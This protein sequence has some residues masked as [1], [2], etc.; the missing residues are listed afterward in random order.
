MPPCG[1]SRRTP[2]SITPGLA[3]CGRHLPQ[4][5]LETTRRMGPGVR[6]DD[7]S[8]ILRAEIF[9]QRRLAIFAIGE[10]CFFQVEIAFDPPSD[11]VGDLAVAQQD[12][13]EFPLR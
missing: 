4:C 9:L 5:L 7:S 10:A 13:D 12:V 11:L 1:S 3:Y 2:G 6:R 8:K